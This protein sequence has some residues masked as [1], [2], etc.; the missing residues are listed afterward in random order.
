MGIYGGSKGLGDKEQQEE[1]GKEEERKKR[2]EEGSG[3]GGKGKEGGKREEEKPVRKRGRRTPW[4]KARMGEGG[5]KWRRRGERRKK[6]ESEKV[7]G[8]PPYESGTSMHVTAA[9]NQ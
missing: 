9:S 2:E 6:R 8:L 5:R 3:K 1:G 7:T 4:S